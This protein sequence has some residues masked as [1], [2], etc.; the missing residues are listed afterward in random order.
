[1]SFTRTAVAAA[2]AALPFAAQAADPNLDEVVVTAPQ[3]REPLVIEND[4]RAPQ[5]PVPASDGASFLKNIPGFSVIRKGGTDGDPVL[6]GLAGSRLNVLLDGAEFHGGC[7][8][9]M[10]PPTA[11]GC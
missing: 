9:R 1:M 10:D 11:R 6:R 4:P 3:M 2:L 8:M 5:Q 7:G